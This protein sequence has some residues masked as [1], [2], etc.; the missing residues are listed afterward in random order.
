MFQDMELHGDDEAAWQRMLDLAAKRIARLID[1]ARRLPEFSDMSV[2]TLE[3][4]VACIVDDDWSEELEVS[5]PAGRGPSKPC[6]TPC[7]AQGVYLVKSWCCSQIRG[8][9]DT[10][11]MPDVFRLISRSRG[12]NF[13]FVSLH[14]TQ[15]A[16]KGENK[17]ISL[18]KEV[19][20]TGSTSHTAAFD[21]DES[22]HLMHGDPPMLKFIVK[23]QIT[24]LHKQC[25]ALL[26]FCAGNRGTVSSK[27][28]QLV[29]V[30]R[31]FCD[32]KR[33]N[34]ANVLR[35]AICLSF[36]IVYDGICWKYLKLSSMS[37]RASYLRQ[38]TCASTVKYRFFAWLWRQ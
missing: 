17:N 28:T 35:K 34:L 24:K 14:I 25:Q 19:M 31:Y 23:N 18:P 1:T 10:K 20:I 11:V 9:I 32:T 30:W 8:S 2:E 4:V 26:S 22:E 27:E 16:C 6:K 15:L 37:S 29:D 5:L 36:Q 21:Y 7:T 3:K 13:A 38:N 12:H 33:Q